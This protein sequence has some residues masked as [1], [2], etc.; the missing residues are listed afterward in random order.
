MTAS[1]TTRK[2]TVS[3]QGAGPGNKRSLI[4]KAATKVF[5]RNGF[6]R[7]QVTDVAKE[8]KVATGTVYLYFR[9][10]EDL[11]TSIFEQSMRSALKSAADTIDKVDDP[12]ERILRL[13]RVHLGELGQDRDLAVVF[14]VELRHST[15]FMV[16]FSAAQVQTYLGHWREAISDAQ[17]CG[18]FRGDINP[19]L[20]A[21]ALFGALDEMATNW[22]L[23]NR[24][25]S[26]VDDADTVVDLLVNGMRKP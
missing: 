22:I 5:A 25:H 10:K 18:Q 1:P 8:A 11:L 20:A 7:S 24:Q 14:Q 16:R 17:A 4:L 2:R 19:M 21:K 13:A 12:V 6:S 15:K 26:L 3:R 23:S 9:S